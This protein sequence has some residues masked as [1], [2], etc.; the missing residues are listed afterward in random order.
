MNK[1]AVLI[2]SGGMDSTTLLYDLI[3]Q[4]YEVF[5]VTFFY[6]QRHKVEV[7]CAKAT[8]EKLGIRGNWMGYPITALSKMGGSSL[9]DLSKPIPKGHYEDENMK[10]TVVPNRNM[11][12][13][14]IAAAHAI[15]LGV[16]ELYYGAHG[17]DHAIYPDCREEFV[18]VMRSAFRL[19]DWAPM[20][21]KA[22]Y[23]H[24]SK[25]DICQKG[26]ALD[27]DYSL[28]HT[29]YDP[30]KSPIN[31]RTLSCGKCGACTERL[32]AFKENGREDT[33]PYV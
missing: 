9:T 13:L 14:A 32:E 2:L 22:P 17:G 28:T 7:E 26:L 3:E 6:G 25:I 33:I 12:L 4:G 27:V 10:D 15:A 30:Q 23:L 29:C 11:T 16:S 24:M 21:L 19:C 1:K 8:C 5:P 20:E 18:N 31:G